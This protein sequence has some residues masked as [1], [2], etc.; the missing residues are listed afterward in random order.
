MNIMVVGDG[1]VGHT[2]A[3]NLAREGHN[4]VIVD[5]NEDTLQ[6]SEDTLD[7]LCVHG[8]GADAKTLLEAEVNKCDILIATTA[9]DEVN[10]LC[11]LIGKRLG[12]KYA[13]ARIRDPEYNKSLSLLQKELDIDLPINPEKATA[14]EISRLLRFP[15]ADNIESFAKGCVEMVEFHAHKEDKVVGRPIKDL[16]GLLPG[17]PQVLYC[18]VERE[19]EVLIPNGDF[20]IQP[21]DRVHVAADISTITAYFRY[22]G[23]SSHRIR[24][25]MLL[26]GS[27]IG[28]YL[29]Q[30]LVPMGIHVK[31]IENNEVK[32]EALSETLP[33]VDVIFGDG[34][35]QDVL[36]Q[37]GLAQLDAFVSLSNRDEDNLI[38]GLYA[39][40]SGVRKVIVKNN[41]IAYGDMFGQMGLDSII[42]PKAITSDV[43]LRYVRALS[44]GEGSAVEKLYRLMNGKAEA[45]E[46]IVKADLPYIGIRLQQLNL[47]ENTLVAVIVRKGKV[48]VPFGGDH[49]EAGD[50]IIII[51]LASGIRDLSEVIRV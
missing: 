45:L 32:A 31:I 47:R 8:N 39:L 35:D 46:F 16:T 9:S 43:I 6:K 34:T 29:A 23:K 17:I 26:G 25:V 49:L 37:E 12:A 2:L 4:V 44:S 20:I 15:F 19:D 38:T 40:R 1:K 11:S 5:R 30:L 22:L 42:S 50:N 24:D 48:I 21:D 10:M 3:A 13:I 33:N 36:D 18:A 27:R 7:V 51:T 14:M 28:Y 41:R